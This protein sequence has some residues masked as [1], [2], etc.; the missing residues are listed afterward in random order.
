MWVPKQLVMGHYVTPAPKKR[1]LI[2]EYTHSTDQW[3]TKDN[4]DT[5]TVDSHTEQIHHTDINLHLSLH[6]DLLVSDSVTEVF[7]M[8]SG[9]DVCSTSCYK[10]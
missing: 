6:Q 9:I 5:L 2:A 7:R 4:A 3:L 8:Y 10:R 1:P